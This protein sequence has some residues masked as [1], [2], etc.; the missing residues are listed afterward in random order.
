M[1]DIKVSAALMGFSLLEQRTILD[2]VKEGKQAPTAR[3]RSAVTQVEEI[4]DS[5]E[6][7]VEGYAGFPIE[8]ELITKNKGKFKDD[9]NIGRVVSQGG[10]SMVITGKKSD[11]RYSVVGKKGE[12]TAKAPEDIGLNMQREWIDIDDL[13]NQMV[14]GMKAARKNVGASSCWDG[15]KAKG[16]KKK[17]GKEVPN[18]VEEEKKDLPKNKMFRKMGNLGR[19]IVSKHTSDEDRQKKYDRQKKMTKVFNKANEEV[20]Q[21][22]ELYKGKHGQSEKEYAD[23]RSSGGKMVSGDS[24]MSGAEYTH[25]RRVK[26][27]NP[28]MQPD[29]GG[30][31]K[32]KSQ[33]K[34]DKGT[35]ADITYRKANLKAKNEEFDALINEIILDEAFDDYTFEELHDICVEALN[36]LD[37]DDLHETFAILDDIELLTEVTSPAKVNALRLKDK[38]SAASGEGQSAGRDAGAEARKRLGDKK[39]EAKPEVGARREKMKAALKSA[40]SAVKKGLKTAGAAASK[41]AG[42]AAGAAGRAAKGAASNFKKGYERGSQGSSGSSSTSS[43][44]SGS[45]SNN[46]GGTTSSSSSEPRTR[47]RDK[48]K[49]G[50]KKVVGG[51]ARSVSRGARGVA[52]RMGEETTYSWRDSMG[53][54]Q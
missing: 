31:T 40:G 50:I 23:S 33:G 6:E 38:A 32:P 52:R 1:L 49:S 7:V 14:E 3:L 22:D 26:A 34:M 25:G 8:K 43:V 4:I 20:E 39:P 44:S 15:Y 41:G 12:K 18:C 54:D 42:Y 13:H 24:K 11:G 17:G 48:I 19:D 16:T 36:E 45:T 46:S 29:V 2:C 5:H 51:V 9:R 37:I 27:A 10:Q 28:G 53:L 47:L 35:R 30:K 21:V